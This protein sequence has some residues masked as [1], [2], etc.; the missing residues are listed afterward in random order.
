MH[1]ADL[2]EPVG[3]LQRSGQEHQ[4]QVRAHRHDRL[5]DPR[6]L[7][8][9]EGRRR[10]NQEQSQPARG[11]SRRNNPAQI[12]KENHFRYSSDTWNLSIYLSWLHIYKLINYIL[13]QY[14]KSNQLF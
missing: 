13:I 2:L 6:K 12:Q 1:D 4:T 11:Q 9:Q 7:Q 10:Q 5:G 14:S 8:S 3:S